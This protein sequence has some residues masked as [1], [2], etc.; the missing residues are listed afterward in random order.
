MA[1]ID[2]KDAD[3]TATSVTR[4]ES[5]GGPIYTVAFNYE[6]DGH[7][8]GGTFTTRDE[9]REGDSVAVRYDPKNP[10]YNDLM[11]KES[12]KRWIIGSVVV[13]VVLL[14]LLAVLH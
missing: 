9:Y 1:K 10:D 3:G 12:R 2:W 11:Q 13:F 7:W 8:C 14:W 4:Q 5:R 6:V